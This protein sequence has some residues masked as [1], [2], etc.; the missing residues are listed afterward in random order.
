M[1][2]QSRDRLVPTV[3]A[4]LVAVGGSAA[5]TAGY[6]FVAQSLE[7]DGSVGRLS[8]GLGLYA[9]AAVAAGTVLW[10]LWRAL[11]DA[12]GRVRVDTSFRLD[13]V[14]SVVAL[15][16][17]VSL[18]W[19]T[20]VLAA[21]E[22]TGAAWLAGGVAL[23]LA[24]VWLYRLCGGLARDAGSA[25]L[26]A[27]VALTVTAG[28]AGWLA[29]SFAVDERYGP[30]VAL[31]CALPL[32]PLGALALRTVDG[33]HLTPV[34]DRGARAVTLLLLS[35]AAGLGGV[36]AR[37]AVDR[38]VGLA[39]LTGLPAL[40]LMLAAR[41]WVGAWAH[42]RMERGRIHRHRF[43]DPHA[44]PVDRW[45]REEEVRCAVRDALEE[46]GYR[47]G[48][49]YTVPARPSGGP[50]RLSP[51][52]L[53]ALASRVAGTIAS[54]VADRVTELL[55]EQIARAASDR[56]GSGVNR[57]VANGLETLRTDLQR[58]IRANVEEM[59][60]GPPLANFT[61]FLS[62]H[63]GD[64]AGEGGGTGHRDGTVLAFAGSRIQLVLA[65]T[66]DDRARDVPASQETAPDR[67]FYIF[68]PVHVQGGR[69]VPTVEFEAVVDS[70]S[71]TPLPQRR[72]LPVA[73]GED[74]QR[75]FA[76][77]LPEQEGRHE[78]WL[79]LYQAGRLVQALALTV[80]A[81]PRVAE[82]A[83]EAGRREA[84]GG[85]GETEVA[86]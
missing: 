45:R 58:S 79:Q 32:I 70:A 9:L 83:D 31:G 62:V 13:V 57:Q 27:V 20:V 67:D 2:T 46:A 39:V 26:A 86:E 61:G 50:G 43:E 82:T 8:L 60:F 7:A 56:I 16:A 35:P 28:S 54:S 68:E 76:F 49:G 5:A 19:L 14:V 18:S 1:A 29:V 17:E 11:A 53:D 72:T 84:H 22:H 78:V 6:R 30:A 4:F 48:G 71:L 25:G 36:T 33:D 75:S 41:W 51:Q 77:Q 42:E 15:P 66:Q 23:A 47:A 40:L 59:V 38:Q 52:E 21:D 24:P 63:L 80:H 74:Q 69:E 37:A 85:T 65:V 81:R 34:D 64:G 3:S 55:A 12:P 73:R 44:R 10:L